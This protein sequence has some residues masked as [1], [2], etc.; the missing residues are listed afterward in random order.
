MKDLVTKL[1]NQA[2]KDFYSISGPMDEMRQQESYRLSNTI[3]MIVFP[4]L[5]IGNTIA[6][7]IALRQPEKVG[8]LLPLTNILI[9]GFTQALASPTGL[10][11]PRQIPPLRWYDGPLCQSSPVCPCLSAKIGGRHDQEKIRT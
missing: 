6:L 10:H 5:V 3:V 1:L 8:F 4:I 2:T 7:L 9:I 11:L